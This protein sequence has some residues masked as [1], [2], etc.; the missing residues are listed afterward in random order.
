MVTLKV[1]LVLSVLGSPLDLNGRDSTWDGMLTVLPPS[2]QTAVEEMHSKT[3]RDE[4]PSAANLKQCAG[5]QG[6]QEQVKALTLL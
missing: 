2:S 6:E 1:I 3:Q 4:I 5:L